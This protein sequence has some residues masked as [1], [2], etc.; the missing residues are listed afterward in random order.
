MDISDWQE[1]SRLR[2]ENHLWHRCLDDIVSAARDHQL[3]SSE[4]AHAI[5]ASVG[6]LNGRLHN[7]GR[8]PVPCASLLR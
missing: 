4:L 3:T 5:Q 6:T 2:L 8:R 1:L 7:M